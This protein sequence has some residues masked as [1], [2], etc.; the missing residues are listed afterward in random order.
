MREIRKQ[1]RQWQR[2]GGRN[3]G[4]S[5]EIAG[6]EGRRGP[7]ARECGQPLGAAKGKERPPKVMQPHQH[8]GFSRGTHSSLLTSK[9]I[10]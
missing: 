6:F 7:W 2:C 4:R 10:R 1:E 9:P 5:D 3:K 8:L